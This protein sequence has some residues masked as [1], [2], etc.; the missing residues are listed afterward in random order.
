[1]GCCSPCPLTVP[2]GG[3]TNGV[4]SVNNAQ[5]VILAANASRKNAI[6]QNQDASVLQV[7]FATGQAFGAG[8]ILLPQYAILELGQ[9]AGVY[10]GIVYGIRAAATGN[11][12]V[13]EET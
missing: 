10:N 2:A 5:T 1:M 6:I 12:G 13:V 8:P 7:Y 3:A 11:V 9:L 4:V